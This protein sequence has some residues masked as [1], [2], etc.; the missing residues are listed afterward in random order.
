MQVGDSTPITPT[1]NPAHI[2]PVRPAVRQS[3]DGRPTE[4]DR[5][6]SARD[7]GQSFRA[8][9]DATRPESAAVQVGLTRSPQ[10]TSPEVLRPER[11][12]ASA[13][14]EIDARESAQLYADTMNTSRGDSP[15]HDGPAEVASTITQQHRSAAHQYA[16][17]FFSVGGTFAA[18]GD[19][20]EVST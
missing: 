7:D 19:K 13:N 5:R 10:A 17:S 18:R 8:T 9:L 12:P 6:D 15:L 14:V 20:L 11:R 4:R 16:Q 2:L 3:G 1:V